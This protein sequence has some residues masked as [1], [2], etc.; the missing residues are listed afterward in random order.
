MTIAEP[1][2][3]E[4]VAAGRSLV[5]EGDGFDRLVKTVEGGTLGVS[6]RRVVPQDPGLIRGVAAHR[7]WAVD[8]SN[9]A[10]DRETAQKK[11]AALRDLIGTLPLAAW[12]RAADD[13]LVWVNPKAE[14]L[15][16]DLVRMTHLSGR[17]R[18]TRRPSSESVTLI[19]D[20]QRKLSMLQKHRTASAAPS[21]TLLT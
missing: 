11:E 2:R 6:G 17:V 4:L 9:L 15:R 8:L 1:D 5:D 21:V 20:G 16:D 18:S 13:T 12:Q 3:G 19:V 10:R 7:I 14:V